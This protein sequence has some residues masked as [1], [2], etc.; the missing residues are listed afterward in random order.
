VVRAASRIT[1]VLAASGSIGTPRGTKPRHDEGELMHKSITAAAAVVMA[2][3]LATVVLA[4]TVNGTAKNDTLRG[5]PKA[6]AI[7]G[8][9]GN[10][11]LYGLAGND[12]LIG[13]AGNDLLDGPAPSHY[14]HV[15]GLVD[16]LGHVQ[17]DE[18]REA[19]YRSRLDPRDRALPRRSRA[20]SR[21]RLRAEMDS[22]PAGAAAA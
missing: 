17:G 2:G 21:A 13:G 10:D 18:V 14:R 11:K 8:K 4:G 16:P 20:L 22:G 19:A 7:N 9:A 5:S 12:K 1:A 6:D 3:L 15:S